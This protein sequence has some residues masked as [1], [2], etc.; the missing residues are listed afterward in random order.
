LLG[1]RAPVLGTNA[2]PFAGKYT[3]VV[4]GARDASVIDRPVGDSFGAVAVDAAGLLTFAGTLAD[5]KPV[6]QS[7]PLSTHGVWPLYVALYGGE[8]SVL[9]WVQLGTNPPP[10]E[11]M[12]GEPLLWFRPPK[13][14]AAYYPNGFE[15]VTS[16]QGSA[17]DKKAKPLL[18]FTNGLLVF[19][20]GGLAEPITNRVLL[21]PSNTVINLE[22][23][24]LTMTITK[25]NG[26][27]NGTNALPGLSTP[28]TFKG[29]LL[30]GLTNGAGFFRHAG[31]SG[32]VLL[33]PAD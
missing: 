19:L 9:S 15:V 32:E 21:S 10:A 18:S 29:V 3:V 14:N 8:G 12:R 28:V 31:L 23:S 11:R 17:Y 4:P 33:L 1:D 22:T 5:G 13:T 30:Q 27:F 25:S 6:T 16:L 26:F 2:S 24:L 7:A 20:G